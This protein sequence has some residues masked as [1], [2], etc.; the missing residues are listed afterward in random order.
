VVDETRPLAGLPADRTLLVKPPIEL[1]VVEI[2]FATDATDVDSTVALAMRAALASVGQDFP[3]LERTQENRV[4][5]QLDPVAGPQTRVAQFARGWQL[6]AVDGSS[7]VTIVAGAV[8]LQTNRYERW[9]VT[10]RP[11]VL[12]MLKVVDSH[13]APTLVARIGLR[14]VDRFVDTTATAATWTGRINPDLL[15]VVSHPVF[16]SHVRSAQQQVEINLGP[17][18]GAMLRHGPFAD[19]AVGGAV[20]YL[21]DI[22]VFDAESTAFEPEALTVRAET[23]N[24]TAATLFQ[25]TLTR[26][27]LLELQGANTT[28]QEGGAA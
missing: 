4:E 6:H 24:R 8:V 23:L 9:S 1:A 13:L 27:Y 5:I 25:A 14:Y 22:D 21:V 7:I 19:P 26:E 11:A 17:A 12:A 28:A 10:L 16:G 18:H 20:S 3:R 15:G 2:R